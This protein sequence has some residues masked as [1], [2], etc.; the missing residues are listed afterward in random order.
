VIEGG[1]W[2]ELAERWGTSWSAARRRYQ[3]AREAIRPRLRGRTQRPAAGDPDPSVVASESGR[4]RP[5][6]RPTPFTAT[7]GRM[8]AADSSALPWERWLD[9]ARARIRQTYRADSVVTREL[10]PGNKSP[11][12]PASVWCVIEQGT[13]GERRLWEICET[14][15]CAER[16]ASE[17]RGPQSGELAVEEWDLS[18]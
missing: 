12:H 10:G 16:L 14:R 1:D 3:R 17:R 4:R 11:P 15:D 8:S 18:Q 7:G 2:D 6:F 5:S 9:C 13:G